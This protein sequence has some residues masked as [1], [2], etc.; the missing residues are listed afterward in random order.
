[1]KNLLSIRLVMLLCAAA[2]LSSC[3]F[4]LRGTAALPPALQTMQVQSAD[5]NGD[6]TRELR[7]VLRNNDVSVDAAESSAY[8]L[9]IGQEQNSE[10]ALSVNSQAR[11]GEYQ[12]TMSVPFQLLNAG[13][14]VLGPE[15]ITLE[16][17]YLADPENA[18]AKSDEAQL[19]QREMRREL[20]LQIL[21]RLQVAQL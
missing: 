11:A 21:R 17:V 4:S 19:I 1:V 5:P 6:I 13:T 7:R 20:A 12:L 8:S 3:G 15:T 2:A 18:A 16:R 9:Q 14:P 10:R